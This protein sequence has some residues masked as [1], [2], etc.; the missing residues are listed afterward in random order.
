[1][2]EHIE[3]LLSVVK[4]VNHQGFDIAQTFD[5]F[6]LHLGGFEFR[7]DLDYILVLSREVFLLEFK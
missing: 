4:L 6:F 2:L 1:M 3:L 7:N 5:N